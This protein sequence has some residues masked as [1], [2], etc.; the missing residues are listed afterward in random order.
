MIE[1]T[2]HNGMDAYLKLMQEFK[3]HPDR[4]YIINGV[5]S[6]KKLW[7]EMYGQPNA[8]HNEYAD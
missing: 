8:Y 6:R 2:G 1:V 4:F 3:E 5:I 7:G